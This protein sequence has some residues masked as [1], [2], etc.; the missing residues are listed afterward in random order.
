MDKKEQNYILPSQL[1]VGIYVHLDLSWMQHPFAL[2]SFKIKDESQVVTIQA[3]GLR[4]VRYDPLRSDCEPLLPDGTAYSAPPE[5]VY[6]V[7]ESLDNTDARVQ[8]VRQLNQAISDCEKGFMRATNAARQALKKLSTHPQEA[9]AEAEALIDGMVDSI[10]TEGDVI[11]HA[12]DGSRLGDDTY[13][14]PMNVTVLALML[15]KSLG[16]NTDESRL[17][18]LAALFHD[19]G[20]ERLPDSVVMNS[21]QLSKVEQSI[22]QQHSE[23]GAAIARQAGLPERVALTMLQHHEL[24]DGSGYPA[25]LKGTEI[26]PMARILALVEAYDQLCNP[27]NPADAMTPYGALSYLFA[28]ERKKYDG[29]TLNLLIKSL[30]VYPPGSIVLLNDGVYGV[31]VSVNPQKLLRPLIMLYDRRAERAVPNILDLGEDTDTSISKCLRAEQLPK[32][33]A[34]YLQCRQRL[35]YFFSTAKAAGDISEAVTT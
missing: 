20:K 29:Q 14:H 7:P 19:A 3:M 31:V 24:N 22:L 10:M 25:G 2:S 18:G 5:N 16:M 6:F 4:R 32:G 15:A 33:V 26:D 30:G 28:S 23:L 27:N 9:I 34:D 1:C 8:R 17:L 21:G 11:I 12:M 35:S 13:F